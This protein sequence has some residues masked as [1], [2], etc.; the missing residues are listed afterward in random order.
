MAAN[1]PPGYLCHM[2]A[3]ATGSDPFKKPAVPR[4]RKTVADK[5]D[6]VSYEERRFPSLVAMCIEVRYRIHW[7]IVGRATKL[8]G[9]AYLPLHR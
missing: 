2:C 8:R 1:P 5:R 9:A 7:D 6:I 4:K 3:K